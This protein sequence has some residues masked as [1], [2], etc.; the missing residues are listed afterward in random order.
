VTTGDG[1]PHLLLL[2][3]ALGASAQFD[4]LAPLL[5]TRFRVHALDFEGH[6]RA[7]PSDRPPRIERLAEQ[8]LAYA[9]AHGI[10]QAHVFGYSM[11]G[12]VG[13]HLAATQAAR[14][15]SVTTLGTK[16]VWDPAL[17]EREAARLDPG[18][19]RTKVPRFASA[20]AERH[21]GAG[22]WE[23][24]LARTAALLRT[25]GTAPLLGPEVLA[26]ITPPVRVMVGDRD[27]T[28]SVEESAAAQRALPSGELAV[29]PRTPHPL[30]QVD[31]ARLAREILRD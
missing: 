25:L 5:S 31:L 12:Y 2:H 30:E 21:E 29:L 6:G 16:F 7:T 19:I 15:A 17:A 26:G 23:G 28:V 11:G 24:V 9:D 13:L 4:A 20:L 14:V 18:V 10:A 22:G 3:G 27:A 8:V 1:L